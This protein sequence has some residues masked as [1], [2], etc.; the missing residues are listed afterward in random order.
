MCKLMKWEND[1]FWSVKTSLLQ[2][3]LSLYPISACT[4]LGKCKTCVRDRVTISQWF[5]TW[6]RQDSSDP[7]PPPLSWLRKRS[8]AGPEMVAHWTRMVVTI[9]SITFSRLWNSI[10]ST[11]WSKPLDI[12]LFIFHQLSWK[13]QIVIFVFSILTGLYRPPLYLDGIKLKKHCKIV[14]WSLKD[15]P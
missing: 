13:I 9:T 3:T 5:S 7:N 12:L 15:F 8:R 10:G 4:A 14:I 11:F 2:L 6:I 1:G